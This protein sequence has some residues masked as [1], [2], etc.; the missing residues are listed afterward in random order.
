M[1]ISK[2]ISAF[3][4]AVFI[5]GCTAATSGPTTQPTAAGVTAA[6]SALLSWSA[7]ASGTD[8]AYRNGLITREQFIAAGPPIETAKAAAIAADNAA[9][10]GA[11]GVQGLETVAASTLATA[12]ATTQP[13]N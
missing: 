4:V 5:A 12:K 7:I 11:S 9:L 6:T 3:I 10:S 8:Q 13:S 2:L 1:R